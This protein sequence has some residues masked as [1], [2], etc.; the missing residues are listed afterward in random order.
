[1]GAEGRRDLGEEKADE[2]EEVAGDLVDG[3][4][5]STL[6][7]NGKCACVDFVV[8]VAVRG[9]G[10]VEPDVSET[11]EFLQMIHQP[12]LFLASFHFVFVYTQY[13]R[14]NFEVS[15]HT[16]IWKYVENNAIAP[17]GMTMS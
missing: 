15:T 10:S 5:D 4:T 16:I 2:A 1:M 12:T 17:L 14:S 7:G 11:I 6:T 3:T 13:S 8:D 9:S